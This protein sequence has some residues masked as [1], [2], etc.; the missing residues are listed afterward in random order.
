MEPTLIATKRY[1]W[2]LYAGW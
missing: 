2:R 1:G